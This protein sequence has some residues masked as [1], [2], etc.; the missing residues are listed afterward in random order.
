MIFKQA[1]RV[2]FVALIWKQYKAAIISTV[3]L[4][5]YLLL[6]KNIHSDILLANTQTNT[7]TNIGWYIAYKWLAYGVGVIAYF[8]FH[9]VR[10]L[11]PSKQNLKDKAKLAN[12]DAIDDEGDPFAAIR[13]RKTL[14][15]RADF[16]DGKE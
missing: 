9:I 8:G 13:D 7:T 1:F 11:R 12:I 3:L 10:S 4:I 14:R 6:V 15:S 16:L 2:A 5:F